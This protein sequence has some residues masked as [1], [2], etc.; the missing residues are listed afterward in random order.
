VTHHVLH[1]T[2]AVQ[3]QRLEPPIRELADLPGR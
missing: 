2:D 1:E 3:A